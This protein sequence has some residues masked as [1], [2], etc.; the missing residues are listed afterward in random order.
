MKLTFATVSTGNYAG[1]GKEY[2]AKLFAGVRANMPRW[3]DL[4]CVCFTDDPSTLPEGVEAIPVLP[5]IS[6]W[7]NKLL[8]F[9]PGTVKRGERILYSDLDAIVIGDLRDLNCY[10]GKFAALRDPFDEN[11]MNSALMSWEAGTLD[12]L[13]TRWDAAGRPQFD[14]RGDQNW[15]SQMCGVQPDY[16]HELLPGQVVSFK[17]DCWRAGRIPDG[18]RVIFFHGH[19]R[20][21]ECRADYIMKLWNRPLKEAI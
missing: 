2:T 8:M 6:G 4:R 14:P 17:K 10:A 13:W 5:G 16:W 21:S 19:P 1:R 15:I 7:W 3:V 11:G 9:R 20:P 12:H 18:A